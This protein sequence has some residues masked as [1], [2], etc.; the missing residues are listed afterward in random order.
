MRPHERYAITNLANQ[1]PNQYWRMFTKLLDTFPDETIR[2]ID[3]VQAQHEL[4]RR[5]ADVATTPEARAM[6]LHGANV[7][8]WVLNEQPD[9][10]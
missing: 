3:E 6:L 7:L 5:A 2:T 9:R 8:R 10:P 1:L 4:A